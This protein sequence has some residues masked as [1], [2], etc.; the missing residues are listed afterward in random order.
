MGPISHVVTGLARI[1]VGFPGAKIS[2]VLGVGAT[3]EL[4]PSAVA[5]QQP[6][7]AGGQSRGDVLDLVGGH[8]VV[9]PHPR[10][11]R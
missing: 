9:D 8:G 3:G 1:S 10:R 6:M 7:G 2:G 4:E 11:Y 5:V